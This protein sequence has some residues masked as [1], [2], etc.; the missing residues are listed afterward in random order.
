MDTL[1]IIGMA[2][3]LI[4]ALDSFAFALWIM[5]GQQPVD[6]FYFGALTANIIKA[7]LALV[8]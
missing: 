5:S 2:L 1:K 3:A 7:I 8:S 4:L 6:G